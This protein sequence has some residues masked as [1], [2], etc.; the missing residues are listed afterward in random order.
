[1][2]FSQLLNFKY[3]IYDHFRF[4]IILLCTVLFA[5]VILFLI[6]TINHG[7]F[8]EFE[9][10]PTFIKRLF[11]NDSTIWAP[12]IVK[13]GSLLI[14]TIWFLVLGN[15]ARSFFYRLLH[16]SLSKKVWKMSEDFNFQCFNDLEIQGVV[17]SYPSKGKPKGFKLT[18][19]DA[20]VLLKPYWK[21]FK[22]EFDFN[23]EGLK[24]SRDAREKVFYETRNNYFGVLFRA[25]DLDNYFMI[26]VGIKKGRLLIKPIIKVNGAWE[27]P[28]DTG[29][30]FVLRDI[31]AN[32][33]FP[34]RCEVKGTIMYLSIGKAVSGFKW[35][36]PN[37]IRPN[38]TGGEKPKTTEG[39]GFLFGDSKNIQF[40]SSYGRIGFRTYGDE[41]VAISNI[42]I[43][44]LSYF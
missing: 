9:L 1:M 29:K 19:S 32:G 44:R 34:A 8:L 14:T 20:G 3:K 18:E 23:F 12:D 28:T 40:R 4:L 33:D 26:Q 39:P 22:L 5:L 24:R 30:D 25:Q 31:K 15:W 2:D 21:D 35:F 7:S 43:T 38:Y 6:H 41:R 17:T 10:L 27:V 16:S 13:T 11:T 37:K 36:L 42:K